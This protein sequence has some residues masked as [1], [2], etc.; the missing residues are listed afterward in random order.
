VHVGEEFEFRDL[1]GS[2]FWGVDLHGSTFRDVNLSQARVSHAE[3][4]GV[5]IDG[6]V[7]DL[8]VN[9]VDVTPFVREHDEWYPLRAMIRADDLAGM[10]A[11]WDE[12]ER[13]WGATIERA[14]ALPADARR[15]SVD[16]EWS[17]VD[18][19]RHLVFAFDKWMTVPVLGGAF[20]PMG[21][22][23]SGS[24][25]FG[26]PGLDLDAD[27]TFDD[28]LA[29]R[30]DRAA[31]LHAFLDTATASDL[32]RTVDVLEN[33]VS[34]VRTCVQ[35]VFEEEFQHHRYAVRDLARL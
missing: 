16:G 12:L 33:G 26:W 23:N 35:V 13:V 15:R 4:V 18:T 17:F 3:L 28:V 25:E 9:G 5:S 11:A 10:R 20:D 24:R 30:A 29:V 32:D 27:P 34:S 14:R 19:L 8:V 6:Y 1:S 31:A 21:I 7:E 2:T 22:P